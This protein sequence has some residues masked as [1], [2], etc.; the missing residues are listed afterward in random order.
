MTWTRKPRSPKYGA[1]WAKTREQWVARHDPMHLCTRCRH[2]LGPMG[3]HL[4]LDHDDLDTDLVRGFAHG[5]P[6]PWCGK[7][8]NQSAGARKGA[9]IVNN[10]R[11]VTQ[12]KW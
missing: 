5:A 9:R 6:C 1:A 11:R 4:H 12:L 8:C 2:P 10:R 3:R 7:R